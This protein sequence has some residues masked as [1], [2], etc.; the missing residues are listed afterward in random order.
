MKNKENGKRKKKQ[1]KYSENY[2]VHAYK[3]RAI[4]GDWSEIFLP[5]D[6][7]TEL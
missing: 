2:P 6:H 5:Q 7:T 1:V 4:S 3:D